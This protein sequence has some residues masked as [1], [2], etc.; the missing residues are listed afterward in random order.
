[1]LKTLN[2][3]QSFK[4]NINIQY[5]KFKAKNYSIAAY[6]IEPIWAIFFDGLS[7]LEFHEENIYWC[8]KILEDERLCDSPERLYAIYII[9]K[10]FYNFEI[11]R[12]IS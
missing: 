5:T 8:R 4:R 1:M 9:A 2:M 6:E 3:S 10:S 11:R 12:K 7:E